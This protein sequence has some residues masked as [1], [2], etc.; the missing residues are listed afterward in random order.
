MGLSSGAE[1][2]YLDEKQM[3]MAYYAT[4]EQLADI[5]RLAASVPD[6]LDPMSLS[7]L[8]VRLRPFRGEIKGILTRGQMVAGIGNAYADEILFDAKIYPFKKRKTS[9]TMNSTASGSPCPT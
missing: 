2:R 3:G 1:L 8:K 7:E 6:V 4:T 5:P 9:Q